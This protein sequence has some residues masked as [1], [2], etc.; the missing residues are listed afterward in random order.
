MKAAILR[1]AHDIRYETV[2]DPIVEPTSI[3]IKVKACGICGS[4]LHLYKLGDKQGTILGHEFSGDV[5]EVGADVSGIKPGDRVIAVGYRP[6]LECYWCKK[7]KVHRCS[8]LALSGN[9]L[10]GAF[11]EYISIPSAQLGINVFKLSAKLTYEEAATVEPLSV[12][13]YS[14]RRAQPQPQDTVAVIGVGIIGLGIIQI[15]KTM[16]VS[17]VIATG[18]RHKRLEMARICG[19]DVVIDAAR[20]DPLAVITEITSGLGVDIV[21]ECAGSPESFHQSIEMVRG[22]GKVILVALYESSIKWDPA[23]VI[24]KNVTLIGCLGGNFPKVLE[25]LESGKINTKPLIAHQFPLNR[26]SEAFETQ[27]KAQDAIKVMVKM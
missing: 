7:G 4:D 19:A 8:N 25:L 20:E 12:G 2:A 15:L 3:V 26:I 18:R 9:Q 24:N 17:R 16:G 21:L 6:C 22:G 27:I 23:I 10:P 14:V 1:G 13:Y 11:A 5:T